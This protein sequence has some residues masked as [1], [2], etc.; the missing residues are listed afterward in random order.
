MPNE[1]IQYAIT[2]YAVQYNIDASF[3]RE[4]HERGLIQLEKQQEEFYVVEEQLPQLDHF[5]R[6][7]CDFEIN[8]AGI[9]VVE[10]LLSKI[11]YLQSQVRLLRSKATLLKDL[12]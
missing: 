12:D 5:T 10:E 11:E 1:P 8:A 6:L 9:E 7:H 3:I 4:L 2:A